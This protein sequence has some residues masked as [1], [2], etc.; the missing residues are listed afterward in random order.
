MN[1]QQ[2]LEE[3]KREF[4]KVYKKTHTEYGLPYT[5]IIKYE[6]V[7]AKDYHTLNLYR[8]KRLRE[9]RKSIVAIITLALYLGS[10]WL[11]NTYTLLDKESIFHVSFGILI[12]G[13][14]CCL[15]INYK[16]NSKKLEKDSFI[17]MFSKE[18]FDNLDFPSPKI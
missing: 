18:N 5:D 3:K 15:C 8:K 1:K 13:V 2:L 10:I 14:L 9:D 6:V 7:F 12:V 4:Q 11:M 17:V 16:A